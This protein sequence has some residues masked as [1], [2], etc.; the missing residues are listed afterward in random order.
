[1]PQRTA[2]WILGEGGGDGALGAAGGGNAQAR[3]SK[4]PLPHAY[5]VYLGLFAPLRAS[6]QVVGPVADFVEVLRQNGKD[7]LYSDEEW[8]LFFL[9]FVEGD[10]DR[11]RD[12]WDGL[13]CQPSYA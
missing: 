2:Q 8:V 7:T 9:P 3:G 6:T 13:L 5:S 10:E 4:P 1:M 12:L 11:A